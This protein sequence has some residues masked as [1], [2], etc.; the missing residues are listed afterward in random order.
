[1][2]TNIVP[3]PLPSFDEILQ[4]LTNVQYAENTAN[5]S[6]MVKKQ[7]DFIGY[8]ADAVKIYRSQEERQI[9]RKK[10]FIKDRVKNYFQSGTRSHITFEVGHTEVEEY[11]SIFDGNHCG[12]V[13]IG[14]PKRKVNGVW[15]PSKR[16]CHKFEVGKDD[17][18]FL[19]THERIE[20]SLQPRYGV[21]FIKKKNYYLKT[22]QFIY[23]PDTKHAQVKFVQVESIKTTEE[24]L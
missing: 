23:F 18:E 12:K 1:M 14:R 22:F 9:Q 11:Y 20:T 10:T 5:L 4:Q 6:K 19:I 17:S 16:I 2:Q 15:T 7:R 8:D 24:K 21:K 3:L 13:S